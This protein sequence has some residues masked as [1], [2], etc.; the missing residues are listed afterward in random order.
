MRGV[1]V[2]IATPGGCSI[3]SNA[4]GCAQRRRALGHRRSR[5][6]AR[7]GFIPD[8]ERESASSVPFTRQTLFFT[9]TM[10]PESSASPAVPAQSGEGRSVAAPTTA[11]NITQKSSKPA[12]SPTKSGTSCAA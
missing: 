4:A 5:P 2:L 1:D 3:I 12:A 9:A 10:P 7:L 8:I 11:A 6:H